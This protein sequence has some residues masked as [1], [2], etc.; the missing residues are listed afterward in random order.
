[1]ERGSI[2]QDVA[3]HS[4]V[5]MVP[6]L[7][8]LHYLQPRIASMQRRVDKTM[9]TVEFEL[10]MLRWIESVAYQHSVAFEVWHIAPHSEYHDAVF[11]RLVDR[12]YDYASRGVSAWEHYD[13][14]TA[15][16][17]LIGSPHIAT[18]Y[19][20]DHDRV[21]RR[22]RYRGYRVPPGGTP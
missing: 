10:M 5:T 4:V 14:E 2:D 8:T 13:E 17:I 18:V 12:L 9:A 1:M 7:V 21:Q 3:Q 16:Q 19:D 20:G 15:Q 11:E 22:W 6:T